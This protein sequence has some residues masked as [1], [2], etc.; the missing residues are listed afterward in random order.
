MSTVPEAHHPGDA[1]AFSRDLYG[2][3]SFLARRRPKLLN[4]GLLAKRDLKALADED[5]RIADFTRFG[6]ET[7]LAESYFRRLLL[8][9]LELTTRAG[10]VVQVDSAAALKHW[11]LPLAE[12]ARAWLAAWPA[13][14]AWHELAYLPSVTWYHPDPRSTSAQPGKARRTVLT[15][16]GKSAGGGA[17]LPVADLLGA[18][19]IGHRDF[20]VPRRGKPSYSGS[21][22][23]DYYGNT[24]G[25]SFSMSLR[26]DTGWLYVE[27]EFVHV[28]L[29][30]LSWLGLLDLRGPDGAP[31]AL[32]LTPLGQHLLA[33]FPPPAF[34][35]VEGGRIVLQPNFHLVAFGPV[36]EVDLIEME[37]FA[38]R[39]SADRAV[40]LTLT[41]ESVYRAQQAGMGAAEVSAAL[42]RLTGAPIPQNVARSLAEWQAAH[43]RV[44]VYRHVSLLQTADEPAL[45]ALTAGDVGRRALRPLA[46]N[47]ALIRDE[48]ALAQRLLAV[49]VAPVIG[50]DRSG[51]GTLALADDGVVSFR[52]PLPDI[53]ALG[54][55]Q[56]LADW[57]ATAEAWRLTADSA[58]R[59]QQREGLPAVKQV[60][61]WRNLSA[62]SAP[63]WLE[64]RIKS[65]CGYYGAATLSDTVLLE[66]RDPEVLAALQDAAGKQLTLTPLAPAGV[67]VSLHRDDVDVVRR[68]LAELG[69]MV[70]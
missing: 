53:Y 18:L 14:G 26:E 56:R 49:G 44:V 8:E 47:L 9:Q 4:A 5:A 51:R 25:W 11:G 34:P 2:L 3:W 59:A 29:L 16:L 46:P 68:L 32:R 65:W 67:V 30:S 61:A 7:E 66:L 43:E 19:K 21:S 22:R 33:D 38:D 50:H 12:R 31:T 41:R 27:S 69:V 70:D 42:T 20:L 10:N 54:Q 45:A 58:R 57:D 17:W 63:D 15:L 6:D 62:G 55:V 36:P 1:A 52:H 23:Y 24:L 60:A 39:V 37:R 28:V 35:A 13:L 64:T 48:P 40:E